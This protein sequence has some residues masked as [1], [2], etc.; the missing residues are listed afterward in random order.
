[1]L[2]NDLGDPGKV[3]IWGE[4]AGAGSVGNHLIAYGGRNDKLFRAAIMQ[5]GTPI[6]LMPLSVK[7]D[8]FNSLIQAIGCADAND[9]LHCLR[10]I[11]FAELNQAI[12]STDLGSSWPPVLDGDFIRDK[13][14]VQ[15]AQG[16]FVPVP[17]IAGANSDE[18]TGFSP[19]GV[20]TESD[21]FDLL[22]SK[23]IFLEDTL[24][25]D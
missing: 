25:F 14:S 6:A 17:I 12:N 9:K 10:Q 15:L 2:T 4:S 13:A 21:F 8:E 11:P 1:M 18:G 5:S 16:K 20:N 24:L 19:M 3:T 23:C 7:Q 22:I